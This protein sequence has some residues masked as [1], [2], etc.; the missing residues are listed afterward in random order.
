[1]L[2]FYTQLAFKNFPVESV[3]M[4]QQLKAPN[5]FQRS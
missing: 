4:V 2:E 1:M 5:A 3:E